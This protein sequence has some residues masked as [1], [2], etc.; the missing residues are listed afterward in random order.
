MSIITIPRRKL[1]R[2][3]LE[4][5]AIGLGCM[6]MSDFYGPS[7]EATNLKVL[8]AALDI[9][10]NFLDTADMYG[11]GANECLLGKVLKSRRSEVVLATKFGIVRGPDGA[12]FGINGTPA[13][14][15]TACDASL[16]RLGVDHIDLYYQHRVDPKV[17]IEETVGAMAEL[18]KAGKVRHLGLSE[19]SAN[20]IRRAA[21][22]HPIAALQSEYS[23]WTRDLEAVILPVCEELGIGVVAY[24][25]LGRGFLTGAFKKLEDFDAGDY[26][27]SSP[28]FSGENFANNLELVEIV[29]QIAREEGYTPAQVALAWLLDCAPY[30]VP[31]PGT[32]SIKRLKENA[33]SVMVRLND[34]QA[35]R[36][37]GIL[38]ERPVIG[39]RYAAASMATIDA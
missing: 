26:R 9:G 16:K 32:R 11:V 37:Y 13:Y 31:I 33:L 23:L 29:S 39:A 21:Q 14:V 8:N 28:R 20:T 7:D 12:S 15:R 10:T 4:V 19:A 25:P 3:G 18:V 6:G 38:R 5:S 35:E 27:H 36:L 24:S 1:G 2:Q 17:A 30:V 22:V 34:A